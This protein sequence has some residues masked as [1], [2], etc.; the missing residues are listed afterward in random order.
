MLI[1]D[2]GDH[3]IVRPVPADPIAALRGSQA[4]PGPSSEETRAEE[5]EA[6]DERDAQRDGPL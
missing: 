2:R 5:R 1:V 6:D 3:A 4:G